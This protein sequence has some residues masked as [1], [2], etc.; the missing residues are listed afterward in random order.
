MWEDVRVVIDYVGVLKV[1]W[2]G[3]TITSW[4]GRQCVGVLKRMVLIQQDN[5]VQ[6]ALTHIRFR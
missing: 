1:Q 6:Q 4:N 5:A 2:R 3:V